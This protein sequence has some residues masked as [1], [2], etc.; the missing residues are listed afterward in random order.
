MKF[1]ARENHENLAHWASPAK[2][3]TSDAKYRGRISK[4]EHACPAV[5]S[6][7]R[8]VKHKYGEY[9][10]YNDLYTKPNQ[11]PENVLRWTNEKPGNGTVDWGTIRTRYW[12]TREQRWTNREPGNGTY[13]QDNVP[14]CDWMSRDQTSVTMND[15]DPRCDSINVE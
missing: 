2:S 6:L 3:P 14:T 1:S 11:D 8:A 5:M 13:G 7:R 9:R 4:S 15:Q 10:G 12:V